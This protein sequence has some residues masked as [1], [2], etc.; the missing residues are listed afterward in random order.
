[1]SPFIVLPIAAL[2]LLITASVMG[3][4]PGPLLSL[5][6][7]G[8]LMGAV[9]A[10]VH[11]AEVVAHRVG[12]PFGT[13]VL[14]LAITIIE[15]AL[16]VSLMLSGGAASA[17]LPRD[18]LYATVMIICNGV[19][20]VCVLVG[21]LR[22]REQSFQTAGTGPALAALAVLCTL[23]LILPVFTTS[24]PV[25]TYTASQLAFTGVVAS[26]LW[27]VYVFVQ[28]VRHRDYFLPE[29]AHADEKCAC[30]S[31][32]PRRS[33]GQRWT[34]DAGAGRGGGAGEEAVAGHRGAGAVGRCARRR[35]RR[36]HRDAGAGCPRPGPPCAPRAP[37]GCRPA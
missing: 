31:A 10:S 35:G 37:T 20:G 36:G 21:G 7:A 2:A 15:V 28:T 24:S 5:L 30:A 16:I 26:A 27:A 8:A 1:M 4:S 11:H 17:T 25:G 9:V 19:V 33:A 23:T 12:E 18:T 29:S 34:A 22:H 3:G 6:C 32:H 13:L 14:A